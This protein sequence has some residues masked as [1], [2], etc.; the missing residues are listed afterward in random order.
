MVILYN[1]EDVTSTFYA[2]QFYNKT[3]SLAISKGHRDSDN[4]TT[5]K[6]DFG[7]GK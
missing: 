6:A 1:E 2:D 7:S 5:V 3:G 4:R